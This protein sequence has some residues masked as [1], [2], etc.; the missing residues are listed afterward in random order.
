MY[1]H[2]CSHI[3]TVLEFVLCRAVWIWA[4]RPEHRYSTLFGLPLNLTLKQNQWWQEVPRRLWFLIQDW[5][6]ACWPIWIIQ[7]SGV[8]DQTICRVECLL[9]FFIFSSSTTCNWNIT[10]ECLFNC[11]HNYEQQCVVL[12]Y[13]GFYKCTLTTDHAQKTWTNCKEQSKLNA[14]EK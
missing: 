4:C 5:S 3:N 7:P 14:F 9:L 12:A 10:F 8:Y 11:V 13:S 6:K 1:A 2:Y